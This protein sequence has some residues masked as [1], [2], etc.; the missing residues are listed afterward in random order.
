M[1]VKPRLTVPFKINSSTNS[2][3][4]LEEYGESK[5]YATCGKEGILLLLFWSL[6]LTQ[7]VFGSSHIVVNFL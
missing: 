2:R 5:E 4:R 6:F 1:R 7:T 3:Y